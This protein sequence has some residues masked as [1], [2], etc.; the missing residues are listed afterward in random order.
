MVTETSCGI[1]GQRFVHGIVDN[2]V[3]QVVQPHLPGRADV[4][5]RTQA[6]RFQ[7]FQHFDTA[8]NRKPA[9]DPVFTSFAIVFL[10]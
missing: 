3:N 6:H 10:A 4:H 1:A 8:W 2:F 5:G 9:M 7:P